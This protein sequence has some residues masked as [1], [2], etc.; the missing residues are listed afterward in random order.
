MK[1]SVLLVSKG[2]VHPSLQARRRLRALLAE[3]AVPGLVAGDGP[4][5]TVSVERGAAP[6]GLSNGAADE[7]EQADRGAGGASQEAAPESRAG[8]EAAAEKGLPPFKVSSRLRRLLDPDPRITAAVVLFF[9]E[10]SPPDGA[11]E[12]LARYVSNGGGLLVIH[13]AVASFKAYSGYAE[14]IGGSFVGHDNPGPV[15][16]YPAEKKR[17]G[18]PS[19][20]TATGQAAGTAAGAAAGAAD[21]RGRASAAGPSGR[22][23]AADSAPIRL[24][25][26]LYRVKVSR[27]VV[28]RYVG[29]S[30]GREEL[31]DQ[32]PVCWERR[33]GSGRVAVV[34][35]GHNAETFGVPAVRTMITEELRRVAGVAGGVDLPGD[36]G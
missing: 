28:V 19:G 9:H 22:D 11:V 34:T 35:L 23:P 24:T 36:E 1:Q 3:E 16:V 13:G 31:V 2:V 12:A 33:H 18:F 26:E 8:G 4:A 15:L 6:A 5:G 29:V 14:L 21:P 7:A 17:P 30:P 32:E 10:K 25:D 20:P 27:D